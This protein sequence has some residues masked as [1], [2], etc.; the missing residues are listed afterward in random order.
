MKQKN[1]VRNKINRFY[2]R[3]RKAYYFKVSSEA[4]EDIPYM[5]AMINQEFNYMVRHSGWC[6][7]KSIKIGEDYND[8]ALGL[9]TVRIDYTYPKYG[10][11]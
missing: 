8:F 1:R 7:N 10:N 9:K 3:E 5:S 4:L 11:L 2:E 6:R